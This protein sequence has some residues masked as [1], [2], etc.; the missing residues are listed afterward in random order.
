MPTRGID[1]KWRRRGSAAMAAWILTLTAAAGSLAAAQDKGDGAR[2]APLDAAGRIDPAKFR[3]W[4]DLISPA[5][6]ETQW[7]SVPWLVSLWEARR[8]AAEEGKPIL[9]WEMDGNPLGCT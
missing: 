3:E 5:P 8:K 1:G 2:P 7:R 6:A 9:L 4:R